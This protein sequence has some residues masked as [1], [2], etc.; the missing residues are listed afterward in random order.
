MSVPWVVDF[1]QLIFHGQIINKAADSHALINR[2]L[3]CHVGLIFHHNVCFLG[4][5]NRQVH[6][7]GAAD[8]VLHGEL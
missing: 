5:L 3:L 2:L 7:R 6:L 1:V 8:G 4:L